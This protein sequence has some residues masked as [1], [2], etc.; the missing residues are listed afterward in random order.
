MADKYL[1]KEG[2]EYF[3]NLLKAEMEKD[4]PLDWGSFEELIAQNGQI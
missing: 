3:Y 4:K 2:L 1:D